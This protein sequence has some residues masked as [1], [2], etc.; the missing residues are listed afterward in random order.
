MLAF[1]ITGFP[2]A[3]HRVHIIWIS[4]VD[5][6]KYVVVDLM[7]YVHHIAFQR[8]TFEHSASGK[9]HM[10]CDLANNFFFSAAAAGFSPPSHWTTKTTGAPGGDWLQRIPGAIG[11]QEYPAQRGL[12]RSRGSSRQSSRGT[13]FMIHL[14]PRAL[15]GDDAELLTVFDSRMCRYM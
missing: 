3:F 1:H 8:F 6:M 12:F 4:P 13:R 14:N 5:L 15:P 11:Y 7:K 2:Y 10:F 9:F